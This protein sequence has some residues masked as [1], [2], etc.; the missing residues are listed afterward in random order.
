MKALVT[1]GAGFIGSHLAEALC[2][3]GANVVILDDFSTGDDSN[4]AW[5][6]PGDAVEVI[7]GGVEDPATA[8]QAVAGCDRVFHEAALVSVPRSIEQPVESHRR[9]V[10]GTLE[11]LVAARDAG[12]RRFVF[13]SSSAVYGENPAPL[14]SESLPPDPRT[15]CRS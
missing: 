2:R 14:K 9:N 11:L 13:A 8:R 10:V 15:P 12:V 4:L 1:G 7:R 3:R 6:K 5:C